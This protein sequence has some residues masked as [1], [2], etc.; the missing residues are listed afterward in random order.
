MNI[1]ASGTG[2]LSSCSQ[3]DTINVCDNTA[4]TASKS[5]EW[6]RRWSI[7]NLITLRLRY[8]RATCINSEHSQENVV[9]SG[10]LQPHMST[11]Y[12]KRCAIR[13]VLCRYSDWGD[14]IVRIRNSSYTK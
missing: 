1:L 9:N 12:P 7:K 2:G 14:E 5:G 13:G 8:K 10:L 11:K 3:H 4:K 6:F